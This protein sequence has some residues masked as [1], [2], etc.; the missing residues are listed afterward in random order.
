MWLEKEWNSREPFSLAGVQNYLRLQWRPEQVRLTHRRLPE[1]FLT[2]GRVH[3]GLDYDTELEAEEDKT[4]T[5]RC[6][7]RFKIQHPWTVDDLKFNLPL[8]R[9]DSNV[10]SNSGLTLALIYLPSQP[11]FEY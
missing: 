9:N 4:T 6:H 1:F 11:T 2:C 3:N 10:K 8:G 5:C 7:I